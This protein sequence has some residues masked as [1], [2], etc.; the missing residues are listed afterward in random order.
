M[1]TII[2][3]SRANVQYSDLLE[4]ISHVDWTITTVISGTA[5][6]ADE[7]GEQWAN[8]TKIPVERYPADWNKYGK[9]AGYKRNLDMANEADALIAI[10]NGKS[11]GTM[12]MINIANKNNLKVYV[13]YVT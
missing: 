3:G 6:G 11:K 7:F 13:H 5:N 8:A 12:H 9:G 2:A 4:A 10:W 1:R